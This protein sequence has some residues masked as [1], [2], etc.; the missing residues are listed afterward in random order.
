MPPQPLYV[1]R[2][3]FTENLSITADHLNVFGG[4][5]SCTTALCCLELAEG[6]SGRFPHRS[7]TLSYSILLSNC[8]F[9]SALKRFQLA[10]RRS[11]KVNIDLPRPLFLPCND[12]VKKI[13]ITEKAFN[14]GP[15]QQAHSALTLARFLLAE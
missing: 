15:S 10:V 13:Y 6:K 4:S 11:D 5:E 1:Q 2:M 3:Y 7:F 14:I 12:G 8:S 9:P